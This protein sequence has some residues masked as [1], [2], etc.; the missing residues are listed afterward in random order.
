MQCWF[1][2]LLFALI[3]FFFL[4]FLFLP[5]PFGLYTCF[6]L[7]FNR[8]MTQLYASWSCE[9]RDKMVSVAEHKAVRAVNSPLSIKLYSTLYT[10]RC[11]LGQGAPLVGSSFNVWYGI[12][13]LFPFFHKLLALSIT[14][15]THTHIYHQPFLFLIPPTLEYYT[16]FF[17]L[18]C[19]CSFSTLSFTIVVFTFKLLRGWTLNWWV[20]PALNS[21]KLTYPSLLDFSLYS[22]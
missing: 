6:Y 15:H 11:F 19:A 8:C 14:T 21:P 1:Y 2:F 18:F 16:F 12:F 10:C 3:V 5:F 22:N 20:G 9:S 13:L 7:S 4:S 17:F